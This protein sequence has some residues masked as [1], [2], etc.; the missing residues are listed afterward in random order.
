MFRVSR[1]D[2][3]LPRHV[4]T[5]KFEVAHQNS[6]GSGEAGVYNSPAL[7]PCTRICTVGTLTA[8]REALAVKQET[9][10]QG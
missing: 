2:I 5:C 1:T 4:L 6:G 3:L 9:G 10:L 7:Q 8:A